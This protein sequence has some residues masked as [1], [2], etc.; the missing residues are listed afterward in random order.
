MYQLVS[1]KKLASWNGRFS[2]N[3]SEWDKVEPQQKAELF[4]NLN[5]NKSFFISGNDVA[6]IFDHLIVFDGTDI[7]NK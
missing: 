3:D 6:R 1:E 4:K 7:K 2:H 5:K